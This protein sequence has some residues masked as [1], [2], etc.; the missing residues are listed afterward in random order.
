M[1]NQGAHGLTPPDFDRRLPAFREGFADF[2]RGAF[3]NPYIRWHGD[4]PY[5]HPRNFLSSREWQHGNDVGFLIT[6][7]FNT[8][9]SEHDD[10]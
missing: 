10:A 4:K 9:V 2:L 3:D 5:I 6:Q 7:H 8:M 1:G